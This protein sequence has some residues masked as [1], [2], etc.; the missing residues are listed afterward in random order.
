MK[1]ITTGINGLDDLLEGG[2]P[3]R[4]LI[5]L[6]G[7]SGTGKTV[8]SLQFL[9]NVAKY[10]PG[11]FVSFEEDISKIKE[12][13]EV[14]GWDIE[15]YENENKLRFLRYDPFRIEDILEVIENNIRE[16][17]AKRVVIDSISAIG[18]YMR[19]PPEI[20]RMILQISNVLRKNNCTAVLTC[21]ILAGKESLSRFGVEEFVVDGLVLLHNFLDKEEYKRSINI[22]KMPS[23]NHSR[24]IHPYSITKEGFT[25][26][27]GEFVRK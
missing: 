9:Y 5:L 27:S 8:F 25:V 20:R 16:I 4:S 11:I 6:S 13:A 1:R 21:D 17:G 24:K 18:L 2:I 10:E 26:H 3:E 23:T 7:T 19:D 22:W 15:R 14:F 12:M